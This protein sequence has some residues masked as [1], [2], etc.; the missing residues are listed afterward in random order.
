M[1]AIA[2]DGPPIAAIV[3]DRALRDDTGFIETASAYAAMALENHRL[4]A[5]ASALLREVNEAQARIRAAADDERRRIERDLHDGAQQRLVALGINLGI[6]AESAGDDGEHAAAVLRR[7]SAEV[8]RTLQELRSLTHG[9]HP[10]PLTDGGLLDGLQA[11]ARV[12]PLPTTV[13]GDGVQ[14]Y[15]PEIEGAAYFCCLEAMQ[16]AAKHAGSATALV[17]ELSARGTLRLEVRDDG[18]GFDLDRV[19]DGTGLVNMRDR[20]AAV[21]GELMIVS[22]PG[23]GTRIVGTIPLAA[24][25]PSR[26]VA[27]TD[28]TKQ[29]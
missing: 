15:P 20:L 9:V 25:T 3:H 13:L 27:T 14:R 8:E 24:A 2:D 10:A 6:A 22:S 1:T 4:T 11:A 28:R 29:E 5:Q 23:H 19:V 18:A 12:S 17:I 26:G 7:L 16:N 21:G